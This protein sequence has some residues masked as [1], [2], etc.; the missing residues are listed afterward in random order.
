MPQPD[1]RARLV[2]G[3]FDMPASDVTARVLDR[4]YAE[5]GRALDVANVYRDGESSTAVGRWLRGRSS[6]DGMVVYAKGC[7]PPYCHPDL[8]AAEVE[9]A[10]TL[11][12]LDRVD[13]FILH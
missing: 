12:G 4:Y 11:L 2:I 7:H 3:S 5:G 10:R 6:A 9:K 13:V 8:V 1:R